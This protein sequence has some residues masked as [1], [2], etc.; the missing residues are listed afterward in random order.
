MELFDHTR[1]TENCGG[2]CEDIC[3]I[4]DNDLNCT[5]VPQNSQCKNSIIWSLLHIAYCTSCY[6]CYNTLDCF[7]D[8]YYWCDAPSCVE[9]ESCVQDPSSNRT[10]YW[11]SS[12]IPTGFNVLETSTCCGDEYS[13]ESGNSTLCPDYSITPSEAD[14]CSVTT[15]TDADNVTC[16][17]CLYTS[18][19]SASYWGESIQTCAVS[20]SWLYDVF[21]ILTVPLT[22]VV[23]IGERVNTEVDMIVAILLAKVSMAWMST[24]M[25]TVAMFVDIIILH[26]IVWVQRTVMEQIQLVGEIALVQ[27]HAIWY[28]VRVS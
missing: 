21:R 3:T 7:D 11:N 15:C 13:S 25:S 23:N 14:C 9:E 1:A 5:Y 19:E 18:A 24:A 20:F 22:N 17:C 8:E 6:H 10:Y 16:E 28:T 2:S 26:T 12:C 4:A 27:I